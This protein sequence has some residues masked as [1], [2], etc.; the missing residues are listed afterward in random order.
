MHKLNVI[1]VTHIVNISRW[2]KQICPIL[3]YTECNLKWI[4]LHSWW[5]NDH[6]LRFVDPLHICLTSLSCSLSSRFSSSCSLKWS[7]PF[8]TTNSCNRYILNLVF[9]VV[10]LINFHEVTE[11]NFFSESV[12]LPTLQPFGYFLQKYIQ[13]KVKSMSCNCYYGVFT[14]IDTETETDEK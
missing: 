7:V 9:C 4:S 14:L 1:T 12:K 6:L 10:S 13:T 11:W 5:P 3:F 2:R 8:S